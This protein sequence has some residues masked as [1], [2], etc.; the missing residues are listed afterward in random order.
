LFYS[1]FSALAYNKWGIKNIGPNDLAGLNTIG[2]FTNNLNYAIQNLLI[3][4]GTIEQNEFK[5]DFNEFVQACISTTHSLKNRKIRLKWF[6]AA[7][8]DKLQEIR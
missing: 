6:V 3:L 1:L 8:Q 7:L 5:K 2:E 4:L